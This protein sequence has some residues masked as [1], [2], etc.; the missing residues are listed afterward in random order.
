[1]FETYRI[2]KQETLRNGWAFAKLMNPGVVYCDILHH[3]LYS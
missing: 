2:T 3:T 1:M